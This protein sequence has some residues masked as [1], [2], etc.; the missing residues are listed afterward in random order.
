[1]THVF[2]IHFTENINNHF[3]NEWNVSDEIPLWT[4]SDTKFWNSISCKQKWKQFYPI[5]SLKFYTIK[6]ENKVMLKRKLIRIRRFLGFL[7]RCWRPGFSNLSTLYLALKIDLHL[8]NL[9]GK[10][11][12]LSACCKPTLIAKGVNC[13]NKHIQKVAFL[14]FM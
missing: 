10:P 3:T 1:M 11:L 2:N 8:N 5:N 6:M 13:R 4:F 14:H 9:I 7:S 12:C